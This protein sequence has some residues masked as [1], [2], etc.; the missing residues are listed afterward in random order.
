MD[1][2]ELTHN[3]KSLQRERKPSGAFRSYVDCMNW[4]DAV[5]AL[6]KYDASLHAEFKTLYDL[7][8]SDEELPSETLYPATNKMLGILNR[9][10]IELQTMPEATD[11]AVA[12]GKKNAPANPPDHKWY[13]RPSGLIILAVTAGVLTWALIEVI[14]VLP[15]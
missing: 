5:Q 7:V 13:Q 3:L 9:A 10:V 1:K 11:V 8:A 4:A 15:L 12:D 6:L 2:I 14:K